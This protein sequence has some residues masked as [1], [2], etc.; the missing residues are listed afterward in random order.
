MKED[1]STGYNHLDTELFKYKLKLINDIRAEI[2]LPAVDISI[3]SDTVNADLTFAV[4]E[5]LNAYKNSPEENTSVKMQY[6]I[7][8]NFDALLAEHTPFIEIKRTYKKSGTQ[9][10]DMYSY[11]GPKANLRTS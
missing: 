7:L 4:N 1:K 8:S 3:I 2:G 6:V 9:G 11:S 10:V 5:T